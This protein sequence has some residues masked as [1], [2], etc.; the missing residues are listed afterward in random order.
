[1]TTRPTILLLAVA[2]GMCAQ[3]VADAQA[4]EPASDPEREAA[5]REAER[6]MRLPRPDVSRVSTP[7]LESALADP[8]RLW[9]L[10]T[11]P[12]TPYVERRAAVVRGAR[13]MP[14]AFV[15]RVVQASAE[16][17]RERDAHRWRL[18][19]HPLDVAA[20]PDPSRAVA[21][22]SRRPV[23]GHEWVVPPEWSDYPITFD[24]EVAAPWP[25]QV[26]QALMQLLPAMAS[27][28]HGGITRHETAES[29]GWMAACM[30]MPIG[31]DDEAEQFIEATL[32]GGAMRA[33]SLPVMARWRQIALHHERP[34]AAL[35]VASEIG[36]V[37]RFWPD[38]RSRDIGEVIVTDMLRRR[39]PD[40]ARDRVG[41]ETARLRQP[42]RDDQPL[43][44]TP[45][46]S[47]LAA[48]ELAADE[49]GGAVWHRL[50]AYAYGASVAVD[51]PPIP[52][53]RIYAGPR[54]PPDSPETVAQLATFV[55]WFRAREQKMQTA[56]AARDAELRP[57]R[58]EMDRLADR[59]TN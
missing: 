8:E 30:T 59:G 24:E 15:P 37:A 29:A 56:A 22:Q 4:L 18:R 32:G 2:V 57:L 7:A 1:M 13:L 34:R 19:P 53:D 42:I 5:F 12:D 44:P 36:D 14:P 55:E 48:S 23:L 10:V 47:V 33:K 17:R 50:T 26:E 41:F 40:E 35:R 20:P 25:W 45:A 39:P 43:E 51:Y 11:A 54:P 27:G 49:G 28:S 21:Q 58:D 9:A 46:T 3:A 52:K 6:K 31:T 16:L 38:P